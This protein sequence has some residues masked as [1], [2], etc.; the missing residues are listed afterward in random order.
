M[1][2]LESVKTKECSCLE[3]SIPL[4]ELTIPEQEVCSSL[5]AFALELADHHSMALP[6]LQPAGRPP[7]DA[8]CASRHHPGS[9]PIGFAGSLWKCYHFFPDG[10]Q[11]SHLFA[12]LRVEI[13]QAAKGNGE[14]RPASKGATVRL[15]RPPSPPPPRLLLLV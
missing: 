4:R 12:R 6:D 14:P 9:Q 11:A 5:S 2:W 3:Q 10:S 7:G 8:G 15:G 1:L 13:S